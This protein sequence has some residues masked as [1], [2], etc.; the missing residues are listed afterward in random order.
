MFASLRRHLASAL[1]LLLLAG[2]A[3][4]CRGDRNGRATEAGDT[5]AAD[6]SRLGATDSVEIAFVQWWREHANRTVLRLAQEDPQAPVSNILVFKLAGGDT[7]AADTE[8]QILDLV[9]QNATLPNV[10]GTFQVYEFPEWERE[11]HL[12]VPEDSPQCAQ[13]QAALVMGGGEPTRFDL[14]P[15]CQSA[16]VPYDIDGISITAYFPH[17]EGAAWIE[18]AYDVTP[19]SQLQL[20]RWS[21]ELESLQLVQTIRECPQVPR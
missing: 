20:F 7:V 10:P 18:F 2:L 11:L 16:N 3:Q 1:P 6:T 17:P 21:P 5:T 8:M 19:C 15:L 9:R 14:N 13:Q 4:G 12:W